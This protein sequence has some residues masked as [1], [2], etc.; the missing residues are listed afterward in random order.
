MAGNSVILKPA[1][2][3]LRTGTWLAKQLWEAGV[4]RDV[5]QLVI[6]EDGETGGTLITHANT[7]AVILTGAYETARLFQGWRPSLRLFAETSGKNALVVSALADRDLVVRDLVRS[8]FGHAGQKCSAAS[9]A[10][11]DAEVHERTSFL[12]RLADAVRSL[13]VGAADD[14]S[15]MMAP[16]IG[17][18]TDKLRRALTTLD[19]G[20]S[21]LVEPRCLDADDRLW[22]PGVKVGVRP[23]SWFHRTECFGPVLGV[24]RAADLDEAIAFQNDVPFGLTG[25]IWT[26]DP[27]EVDRWV[28]QVEVG[29]AYVNRHTTGAIVRRQPFGGWKRSVVGPG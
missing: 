11:L 1:P 20:E 9:L 7:D 16:L 17:P 25:G 19:E 28:E 15:T 12:P 13:R 22:T 26:L 5:L 27:T 14:L 21:W 10:I 8:A 6:C 29:N 2:E 4:P 18:P 23:G 3:T 24:M